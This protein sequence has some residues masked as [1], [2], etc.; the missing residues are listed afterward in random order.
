MGGVEMSEQKTIKAGQ[1]TITFSTSERHA[2]AKGWTT[3]EMLWDVPPPLEVM[4][5]GGAPD[6]DYDDGV[7]RVF[8]KGEAWVSIDKRRHAGR[9]GLAAQL[10]R[11][12]NQVGKPE[13]LRQQV[14]ALLGGTAVQDAARAMPRFIEPDTSIYTETVSEPFVVLEKE[15]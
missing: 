11:M 3:G 10:R 4:H 7:T 9:H 13:M 6:A 14:M 15:G 1:S 5:G 8:D 12:G 2:R